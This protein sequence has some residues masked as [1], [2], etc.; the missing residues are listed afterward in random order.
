MMAD[1]DDMANDSGRWWGSII[2]P[3]VF[4][5]PPPL[6][7]PIFTIPCHAVRQ[8]QQGSPSAAEAKHGQ[9]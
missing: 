2:L 6:S 8:G 5:E 1:V 9:A 3:G 4:S 7:G